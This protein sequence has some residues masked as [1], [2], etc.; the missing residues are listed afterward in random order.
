MVLNLFVDQFGLFEIGVR[1]VEA[2][3]MARETVRFGWAMLARN[4]SDVVPPR[5]GVHPAA[6]KR[7]RRGV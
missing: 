6:L 1:K 7:R 4:K 2:G 3:S 5:G